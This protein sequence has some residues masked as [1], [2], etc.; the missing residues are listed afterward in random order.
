L[1]GTPK[2]MRERFATADFNRKSRQRIAL[3]CNYL[4]AA[5]AHCCG[6]APDKDAAAGRPELDPA[7]R[8]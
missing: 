4:L 1:H 2:R 7:S 3:E 6:S 8:R 5:M